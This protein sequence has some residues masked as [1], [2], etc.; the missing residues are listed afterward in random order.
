LVIFILA[1]SQFT[2]ILDFM[3]MSPLGDLLIKS[4]DMHASSFGIV[5]SAYAFSAGVSGLLTAGFA[6]KYDR[7]KLLLFFYTGFII[8]TIF[9]GIADTF[10][11]LVAARII[12]GLFGGVIGSISM[13]IITD[14]FALE[15]RGRVMGFVQMGFGASQVLGIPIGLY[16]ANKMGWEA[17]FLFIAG[18]AILIAIVIVVRLKPVDAHLGMEVQ[19]K[20]I[21]HLVQTLKK[22]P[23]HVGF[24][25]TAV[26]S[27]GGFM[28]MPYG[29]VFA[30][31]NLGI[32]NEQWPFLF[33]ASG[34]SSLLI[35][36]IIGKTSDSVNKYKLFA[37]ATI[38][39]RVICVIYSNLS[40]A[41]FVWVL[42]ITICMMMGSMSPRVPSSSVVSGVPDMQA[43]GAFR[44]IKASLQQ[45][46]GGIAA[47]IAGLIVYPQN[48]FSPLE[49]YDMVGYAVV[50]IS[51]VSILLM[52]RVDRLVKAKISN[53][54]SSVLDK[55]TAPSTHT[56]S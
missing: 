29:T 9:C 1:I 31:N 15:K 41:R 30:V 8:G 46:E 14:L 3:V 51:L 32:S 35:M 21:S 49:R 52:Y 47:T 26:L 44:R 24:L 10:Y 38:C 12:T 17:P 7:K 20:A 48:K 18:L 40:S 6:D 54:P 43:R 13:A 5:V 19:K 22:K 55:P 45:I 4:M 2:V 56:Q 53:I 27:V 34:V 28:M 33:M 37:G 11:T 25:T 50:A 42:V 16:I 39:L 36:P 23:Y